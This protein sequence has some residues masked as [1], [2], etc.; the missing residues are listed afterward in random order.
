MEVSTKTKLEEAENAV[1]LIPSKSFTKPVKCRSRRERGSVDR[2]E[3]EVLFFLEN[4]WYL[5]VRLAPYLSRRSCSWMHYET[6][7]WTARAMR[8]F[9][10]EWLW[11]VPPCIVFRDCGSCFASPNTEFRGRLY[12]CEVSNIIRRNVFFKQGTVC[13]QYSRQNTVFFNKT[14]FFPS[15]KDLFSSVN[16]LMPCL[17]YSLFHQNCFLASRR[18]LFAYQEH[19][20]A[21]LFR[22][23]KNSFP[24]IKYVC[25]FA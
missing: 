15:G 4:G 24:W 13:F 22:L 6:R 19:V 7:N 21:L 23:K 1:P 18:C 17:Y 14:F 25:F 5:L 16:F 12:R 3:R 11:L 20:S 10:E 9:L 8:C 2:S